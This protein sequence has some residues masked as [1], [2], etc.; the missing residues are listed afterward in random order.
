MTA[1]L[2]AALAAALLL[3]WRMART[4]L[5][6]AA[7]ALL[8]VT[9]VLQPRLLGDN[10]L[11]HLLFATLLPASLAALS[12]AGEHGFTLRQLRNQLA[13]AFAPLLI[14]AVFCAGRT[15]QAIHLLSS[16]AII[17]AL[18]GFAVAIFAA[19]RARRA[20]EIGMACV[21]LA[22]IGAFASAAGTNARTSWL[23][24][25]SIGLVIALVETAYHMAFH[26][27]L[28]GLPTRRALAGRLRKLQPPYAIAVVDVDH[29]KSFN[30]EHGHDVGDQVLRMVAAKLRAVKGGGAAYRTGGEEFTIVFAGLQPADALPHVDVVRETIA[31]TQF[32]LR[33]MPRPRRNGSDRRRRKGKAESDALQV[34]ISVGIA[35]AK[36][37]S[38]N[39]ESVLRAA[40]Q[41]MYRAKSEGRN[42]VIA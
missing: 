10:A 2:Y 34:T 11:A 22:L 38:A 16:I 4:R 31:Q 25:G 21:V 14:V 28:T 6:V 40:D 7:I 3:S 20:P 32:A 42:R 5:F 35:A 39:I 24:A 17:G 33:R 13:I 27:E 36:T 26:D 18:V 29:F 19:V 9:I 30:D 41:A 37:R 12:F 15:A 23:L 1:Y 8:V